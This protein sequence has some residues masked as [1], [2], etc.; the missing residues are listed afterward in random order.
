MLV[1]DASLV[2]LL[3]RALE[4]ANYT[5]A[6]LAAARRDGS[7]AGARARRVANPA[8]KLANLD[9]LF[10][11]GDPCDPALAE[12]ALMPLSLRDAETLG[13]IEMDTHVTRARVRLTPYQHC[14]FAS[15]RPEQGKQLVAGVDAP[16]ITLSRLTVRRPVA[17]ALD[18][19]TGCGVQSVLAAEH[20]ERVVATDVNP[21][22]V[23]YATFN[24]MLNGVSNTEF[25]QGSWFEPVAGEQFELIMSNPP[26]VLSPDTTYDYRDSDLPGDDVCRH[27]VSTAGRHLAESGFATILCNWAHDPAAAWDAPVRGW[28]ADDCDALVLRYATDSPDAYARRWNRNLAGVDP[29]AFERTVERWLAYYRKNRINAIASG[30]VI[31]RKRTAGTRFFTAIDAG[32]PPTGPGSD[33][34]LRI[35]AAHDY[36]QSLANEAAMLDD[37]FALVAGHRLDQSLTYTDGTY[38]THASVMRVIPG[39]GLDCEVEAPA[40]HILFALEGDRSLGDAASDA[41]AN[42]G[43]TRKAA[44]RLALTTVRALLERGFAAPVSGTEH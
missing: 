28:V 22:A 44:E 33:H 34:I 26:Y 42:L 6:G 40:V 18:L 27:V 21:L 17:S 12:A 13:I 19:G 24:A 36:L 15:G 4:A 35:F 37:A 23:E 14:V 32:A 31:L 20:C 1:A 3:R 11:A 8:S 38:R 5:E 10:S 16:S 9:G 43:L 25:L 7:S 2:E 29:D 39:I 41:A 30:A